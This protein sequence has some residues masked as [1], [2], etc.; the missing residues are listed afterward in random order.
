[1]VLRVVQCGNLKTCFDKS[2][3]RRTSVCG[4]GGGGGACER[5]LP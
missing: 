3:N 4:G 2:R 5:E 1:M